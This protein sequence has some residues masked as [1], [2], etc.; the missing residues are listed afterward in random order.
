MEILPCLF[1][2]HISP[3][4]DTFPHIRTNLFFTHSFSSFPLPQHKILLS[5]SVN[6]HNLSLSLFPLSNGSFEILPSNQ[7]PP[8]LSRANENWEWFALQLILGW[9]FLG[10]MRHKNIPSSNQIGWQSSW[11]MR[12][13]DSSF[14][15]SWISWWGF[16]AWFLS[17]LSV[18]S[19]I[20]LLHPNYFK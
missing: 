11:L 9:E 10:P 6:L 4:N 3:M 14:P 1:L 5:P 2:A 7:R 20:L 13:E 15:L 16:W 12:L 8:H 19:H 17:S 18:D